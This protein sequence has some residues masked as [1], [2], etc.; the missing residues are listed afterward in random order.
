MENKIMKTVAQLGVI[1]V[2]IY[3]VATLLGR[4]EEATLQANARS[5]YRLKH[6]PRSNSNVNYATS[7]VVA[8][9]AEGAPYFQPPVQPLTRY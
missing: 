5:N 1:A 3:V 7:V 4:S 2:A 9:K 6:Q 8:P